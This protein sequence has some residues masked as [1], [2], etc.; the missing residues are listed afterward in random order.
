VQKRITD[1][2][3]IE[4]SELLRTHAKEIQQSHS[5]LSTGASPVGCVAGAVVS[6]GNQ[7]GG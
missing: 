5:V 3:T 7:M 2:K 1:K 4:T 6:T